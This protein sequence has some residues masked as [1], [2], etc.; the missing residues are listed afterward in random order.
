[1]HR[2]LLSAVLDLEKGQSLS[3]RACNVATYHLLHQTL[4][5]GLWR[6]AQCSPEL[7]HREWVAQR[8][9][10]LSL[11][12]QAEQA[13]YAVQNLADPMKV[14]VSVMG[15]VCDVECSR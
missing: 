12:V 6:A 11:P 13:T 9:L 8:D 3:C 4:T 7:R 10:E 2:I 14:R 15:C 1:M 5:G